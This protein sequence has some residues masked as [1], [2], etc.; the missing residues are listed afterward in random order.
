[1]RALDAAL[2][3]FHVER[4]AFYSG[5]FIGN[6]VHRSLQVYKMN[7]YHR[8]FTMKVVHVLY[9]A[10][11]HRQTLSLSDSRSRDTLPLSF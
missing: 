2:A 11:E 9:L 3:S 1:M 7:T 10:P 8:E 4:Q 6:H 5:A